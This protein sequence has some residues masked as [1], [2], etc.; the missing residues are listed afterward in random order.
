AAGGSVVS[1]GAALER[2][3]VARVH[4]AAPVVREAAVIGASVI[5][6]AGVAAAPRVGRAAYV[7][8]AT[9]VVARAPAVVGAAVIVPTPV[10][11]PIVAPRSIVTGAAAVEAGVGRDSCVARAALSR[12]GLG[13]R[14]EGARIRAAATAERQDRQRRRDHITH[15]ANGT[16][17][18]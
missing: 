11:R 1:P 3:V 14:A 17:A 13:Q 15:R 6:P 12:S 4:G 18:R 9:R 7:H 8:A 10:R 2:R 5:S 16:S